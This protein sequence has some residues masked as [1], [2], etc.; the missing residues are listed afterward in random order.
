MYQYSWSQEYSV[1]NDTIDGHHQHLFDLFNDSY[2]LL[3][4]S[5]SSSQTQKLISDLR[6][7]TIFHFK[8]EEKAF[9]ATSY[10]LIDEHLKLHH[11]F[12]EQLTHFED[13]LKTD[14]DAI[15][16]ELF[17]FLNQWLIEHIQKQDRGY[18]SY[19]G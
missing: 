16:E 10:P 12:I 9:M 3:I 17:L 5:P 8:E 7:Y 15:N 4:A 14:P 18:M 13:L 2:N 19:I 1:G 11:Y 6:L